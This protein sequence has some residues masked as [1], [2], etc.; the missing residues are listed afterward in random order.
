MHN[1][2]ALQV[3]GNLCPQPEKYAYNLLVPSYNLYFYLFN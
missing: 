2:F 1:P 3:W